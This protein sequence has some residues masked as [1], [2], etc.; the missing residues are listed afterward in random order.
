MVTA[1]AHGARS[2]LPV[3]SLDEAKC[4]LGKEGHLCAAER[5]GAQVE[6]FPL[7]NS[8]FSYM[9]DDVKDACLVI[10]T[11]N[12]TLAI[13]KSIDAEEVLVGAFV[14]LS[15]VAKYLTENKKDV[16]IHCAG[17]K[18][19]TNMEDTLYAGA[20]VEKLLHS[21]DIGCDTPRLALNYY[22]S[23]KGD[24]L[25]T[26]KKSSHARRLNRLHIEKDIEFCVSFDKYDVV[27]VLR[28]GYLEALNPVVIE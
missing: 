20:L 11:T 24:L 8:P 16:L 7:D 21:H 4:H 6:G 19:K 17:W 9:N 3:A 13:T 22:Q 18:G 23:V 25:R 1:M 26:V 14:N 10:T 12:G 5:G 27:P 28:N 15:A 2:I